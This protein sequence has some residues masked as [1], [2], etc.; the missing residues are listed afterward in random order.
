[1]AK[2]ETQLDGQCC[3]SRWSLSYSS[4]VDMQGGDFFIVLSLDSVRYTFLYEEAK[5]FSL[6]PQSEAEVSLVFSVLLYNRIKQT[7]FWSEWLEYL[8]FNTVCNKAYLN[9]SALPFHVCSDRP[10]HECDIVS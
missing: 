8:I 4:A 5:E 6:M 9:A 2:P 10:A 3:R 1:M 7:S